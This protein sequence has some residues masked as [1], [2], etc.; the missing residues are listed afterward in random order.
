MKI[1]YFLLW[2]VHQVLKATSKAFTVRH[3][4][5]IEWRVFRRVCMKNRV[6]NDRKFFEKFP[7][8]LLMRK[9][10]WGKFKI[11]KRYFEYFFPLCFYSEF[12]HSQN[13]R[14]GFSNIFLLFFCTIFFKHTLVLS[15]VLLYKQVEILK[16]SFIFSLYFL[17]FLYWYKYN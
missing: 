14:T 17:F 9:Y 7:L 4:F 11:N 5:T 3:G 1:K 10:R 16:A 13:I 6:N 12:P 2:V 8:L 15:I